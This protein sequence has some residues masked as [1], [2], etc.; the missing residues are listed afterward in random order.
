[1]NNCMHVHIV[2]RRLPYASTTFSKPIYH[3]GNRPKPTSGQTETCW[4]STA[5]IN[6]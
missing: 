2:H 1:M 4:L 5:Q 6:Y 3:Q